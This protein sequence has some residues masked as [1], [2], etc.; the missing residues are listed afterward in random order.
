[1]VLLA[2]DATQWQDL[3]S[4]LDDGQGAL[5]IA[6]E[7]LQAAIANLTSVAGEC[8]ILLTAIRDNTEQV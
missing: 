5:A 3:I 8:Q 2:F 7:D 1:M 6:L 4:K